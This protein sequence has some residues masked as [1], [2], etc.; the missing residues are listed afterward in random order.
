MRT[1]YSVNVKKGYTAASFANYRLPPSVVTAVV[2]AA[3]QSLAKTTWSSY[4]TAEAHLMRCEKDTKVKMRF[5]M[6]DRMILTYVGWL[7]SARGVSAS[8]ITQ[9]ISGLRVVHLKK[10]V[11]PG[12]LRPDIVNAIIKGRAHEDCTKEKAPRMAMTIP[13]MK[14]LKLLLTKSRMCHEEKRLL[15]AVSCIAFHGSFRIHELLSRVS[16]EFDPTTTLLGCN[17]ILKTVD[18]DGTREELMLIHLKSPKEEKLSGGVTVELFATNTFSCPVSAWKKWRKVSKVSASKSSPVF[19]LPNGSCLTG[20]RFNKEIKALLGKYI[21]YDEKK[22]LS[23]S[24]RAGMAS[25]MA[26]AGM[27]DEDIMR[28]GRWHSRQSCSWNQGKWKYLML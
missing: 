24:F 4:N 27:R 11:F 23:H 18:V 21:N 20:N 5:P 1:K 13:V 19:R 7:I 2:N 17:V 6:D 12:N 14:L 26:A 10:G 3:N 22:Y 28:Q 8:S 25:M 15:W 16:N 9:Y